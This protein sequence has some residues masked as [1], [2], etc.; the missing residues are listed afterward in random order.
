MSYSGV[1][2]MRGLTKREPAG[3]GENVWKLH[4]HGDGERLTGA[5]CA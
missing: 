1:R 2:N 3:Y 5:Y 4:S